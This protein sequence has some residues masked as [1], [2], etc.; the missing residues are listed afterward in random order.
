MDAA[1]DH[2]AAFAHG[3]QGLRDQFAGGGEED[4][5]VQ[6]LGRVRV[7]VAG[8]G[9]ALHAGEFLCGEIAGAGEGQY[10]PALVA[11]DLGHQ[12][13][14]GAEAVDA[15]GSRFAGALQGAPA[16]QSRAQQRC[17]GHGVD[18]AQ[19]DAEVGACDE[20]AGEAAGSG[21]A[22]ELRCVAEVLAAAAAVV[23][24][25]AGG[26]Q[27]RHADALADGEVV[28]AKAE[29][30]DQADHLV[31]R[32]DRQPQVRQ[33]AVDHVQVGAAD[34]A[35]FHAQAHFAVAGFGVV[36]LAQYQ[37]SMDGFERHR[38]HGR[39]LNAGTARAAAR[40]TARAASR[41]RAPIR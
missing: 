17:G 39:S 25:A 23:A 30:F 1:A 3:A 15:D 32:H 11:G 8:P 41:R 35:G 21:V 7:G 33:F 26:A 27:P 16:D 6:W 22:S 12:V 18:L 24:D 34:A 13:R 5:G 10:S 19:R 4:G 37:G 36:V 29:A 31:P 40:S 28:D 9:G 20:V 2:A 38:A 14:G